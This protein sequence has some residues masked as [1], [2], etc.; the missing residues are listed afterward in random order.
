MK[1]LIILSIIIVLIG[2]LLIGIAYL[3]GFRKDK[4]NKMRFDSKHRYDGILMTGISFVIA[5]ML[6]LILL[7]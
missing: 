2:L 1:E 4:N 3:Y 6:S 7:V 5:G